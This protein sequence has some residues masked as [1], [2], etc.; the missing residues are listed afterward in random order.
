MA[1]SWM[2]PC[3]V[4]FVG[5]WCFLATLMPSELSTIT[6]LRSGKTNAI[7]P[8]LP[9]SLPWMTCTWSPFLSFI[10]GF[11]LII[12]RSRRCAP[13]RSGPASL[14]AG[15]PGSR[16]LRSCSQHLRRERHD[17]HE[18]AVTQLPTH[19]AEDARAARLHL[20]V[21]QHRRVLVEADVAAVGTAA[22]L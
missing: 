4:A 9:M 12:L 16:P 5:F 13:G 21:D 7:S 14:R 1:L 11:V 6:L 10:L 2:P 17:A 19:R 15:I 8:R 3:M 18:P 20:L 22:L